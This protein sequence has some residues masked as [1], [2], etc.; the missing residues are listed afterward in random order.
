MIEAMIKLLD[1]NKKYDLFEG[2]QHPKFNLVRYN[3]RGLG[4]FAEEISARWFCSRED[5]T[6]IEVQ[7][8]NS[9]WY[10]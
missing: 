7:K 2:P 3:N 9:S 10:H 6:T 8:I 5:I 4:L 1:L